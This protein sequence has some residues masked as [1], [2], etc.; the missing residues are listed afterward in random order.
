MNKTLYTPSYSQPLYTVD[1]HQEGTIVYTDNGVIQQEPIKGEVVEAVPVSVKHVFEIWADPECTTRPTEANYVYVQVNKDLTLND[2]AIY[3]SDN[4]VD[5]DFEFW[6]EDNIW[7]LRFW[8]D[9]QSGNLYSA[10]KKGDVIKLQL[11]Q[12][13]IFD[14]SN[15]PFSF[16]EIVES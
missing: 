15:K 3:G 13:Q 6:E 8:F 2:V 5:A 9:F 7:G 10:P 16:G 14:V 11:G 4:S 12:E 1:K